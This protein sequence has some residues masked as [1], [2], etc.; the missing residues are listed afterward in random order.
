MKFYYTNPLTFA[1]DLEIPHRT[2]KINDI[3]KFDAPFFGVHSKQANF[4]D[5]MSRMLLEHSY[6]AIVDAGV[7]PGQLKGSNTGIFI[8][9]CVSESEKTLL[10]EKVNGLGIAGCTRAMLANRIS[11]WLDAKGPSYNVDSACSSSCCALENA[12]WAMR[13]GRCDAAIV[14]ASHIC[15]HPKV[16]LQ[17]VKL[18]KI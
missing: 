14:G 11:H 3:E 5:P 13:N 16:S 18:G 4:M 2:G 1:D 15:L 8:G 12:Y 9:N 17:F 7:N 6:E 10:Y